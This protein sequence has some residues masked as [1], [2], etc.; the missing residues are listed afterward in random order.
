MIDL[1]KVAVCL[2]GAGSKGIIQLGMLKRW[3]ELG[4][5]YDALYTSSVGS[6]NGMMLHQGSTYEEMESL[7]MNVRTRDIYSNSWFNFLG[8]FPSFFNSSPLANLIEKRLKY[9]AIKSNP[10]PMTI[11]TT[12]FIAGD[13]ASFL[14]SDLEREDLSRV[15]LASAS[16]PVYFPPVRMWGRVLYDSGVV[17][18]FGLAQAIRDGA[19]TIISMNFANKE[20]CEVNNVKDALAGALVISTNGYFRREYGTIETINNLIEKANDE[21]THFRKIRIINLQPDK[22]IGMGFLDFDYKDMDRRGLIQMGYDIAAKGLQ[23]LI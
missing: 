7:W 17:N 1:G 18:N 6:L 20:P 8:K 15:L 21:D 2:A 16:P 9:E 12:D 10:V 22:A 14:A 5:K 11:N 3:L 19:D 23:C 13:G 4:F